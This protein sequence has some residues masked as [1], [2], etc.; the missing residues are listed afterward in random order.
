MSTS[1][2]SDKAVWDKL[3][4]HVGRGEEAVELVKQLFSE[5][6]PY[7]Q[8]KPSEETWHKVCRFVEYDDSE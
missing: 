2:K 6:G 1:S 4:S 3:V 7:R 8:D 5:I